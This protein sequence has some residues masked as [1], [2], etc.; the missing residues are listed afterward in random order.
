MDYNFIMSL[1]AIAMLLLDVKLHFLVY[2]R[3]I[4]TH[5]ISTV[6]VFYFKVLGLGHPMKFMHVSNGPPVHQMSFGNCMRV[7]LALQEPFLVL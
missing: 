6:E 1:P 2:S 7:L 4:Y 3:L 5:C